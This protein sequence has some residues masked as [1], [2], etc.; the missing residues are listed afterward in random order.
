[1]NNLENTVNSTSD[2]VSEAK[3]EF[4]NLLGVAAE[5]QLTTT[6]Q[7]QP[8]PDK[9]TSKAQ[10]TQSEFRPL[11][12]M[13]Q[14]IRT[15]FLHRPQR[16]LL[17]LS[18]A[19]IL[20]HAFT[21]TLGF[22]T[23]MIWL[24]IMMVLTKLNHLSSKYSAKV[25]RYSI[26]VYKNNFLENDCW[27]IGWDDIKSV[28]LISKEGA[29]PNLV[30]IQLYRTP[31]YHQM[32]IFNDMEH[33]GS[34][35]NISID[36]MPNQEARRLF[37]DSLTKYCPPQIL[38]EGEMPTEDVISD[39]ELILGAEEGYVLSYLPLHFFQKY[40]EKTLHFID[41]YL[42]IPTTILTVI[43]ILNFG[44][45]AFLMLA[46][47][48]VIPFIGL[49]QIIYKRTLFVVFTKTGISSAWQWRGLQRSKEISWDSIIQVIHVPSTSDPN[50]EGLDFVIDQ[51]S[52]DAKKAR[53]IARIPV[54]PF[55][56]SQNYPF[57]RLDFKGFIS[58]N[59]KHE[60][61][62]AI[63]QFLPP[64]KIQDELKQVLN[65]TDIQSYTQ[66]W[67]DSLGKNSIRRYDGKLAVGQQLKNGE[68]EII[69]LLGAGGQASAYLAK[70]NR[71]QYSK[72]ETNNS[73]VLKEFILPSH[74]G[75][76]LSMR[77][78]AHIQK[79]LD[80][81]K[82]LEHKNIVKYH[83]IF[84]EDHRCYLVLEHVNGKSLRSIVE[85]SGAMPEKQVKD[86]AFQMAQILEHLHSQ[87]PAIIH[88]DFT[89]ENLILDQDGTLK[90]IDFNVAQELEEGATRTIVGKHAYLPP[91]Q[92]R[93][94]ACAQSDIYAFGAT[95]HFLLT[96]E[97]PEPISCSHPIII[98]DSVS[99]ELDALVASSTELELSKRLKSAA[100]IKTMLDDIIS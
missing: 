11:W 95:V 7:S 100:D 73:I 31:Q 54:D 20:L 35:F 13:Q 80:L 93:G 42:V 56:E 59:A 36:S 82:R 87:N 15:R 62:S 81:M 1:M 88:R 76:E 89:P 4:K 94:K 85:E 51:N 71:G 83:D 33:S 38:R 53:S 52:D 79:E 14:A 26:E 49:L 34:S 46:A 8:E 40:L 69:D 12:N 50:K 58:A 77:S 99:P 2:V 9:E 44:M 18:A 86:L 70:D 92:F 60:I 75:A 91:E 3:Q 21:G 48:L 30:S 41:K 29:E 90:L 37:L 68:F 39:K 61:L 98:N 96:G 66:L 78:I 55:D 47:A 28:Q 25:D 67:L 5:T 43:F 22:A 27:R 97:D 10:A 24:T 57:H 23:L 65:P 17:T 19:V 64:N 84:V 32:Q 74:A 6:S 72:K 16:V 45:G 63:T